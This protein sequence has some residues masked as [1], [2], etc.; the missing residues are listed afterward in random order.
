MDNGNTP[1]AA[2]V[3]TVHI[4]PNN[5]RLSPQAMRMLTKATGRTMSQLMESPEDA[6]K[7][8]A[9]AFF[10]LRRRH[11]NLSAEDLWDRAG[12]VEIELGAVV[13]ADPFGTAPSTGSPTSPTTG[14]STPTTSTT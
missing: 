12:T 1:A 8:Q 2:D 3:E 13:T 10:E 6:D 11:P 4:D 5:V 9:M 7:F 14:A